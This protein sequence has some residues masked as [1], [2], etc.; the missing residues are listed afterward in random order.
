[1][2]ATARR[3]AVVTGASSGIGR[4]TALELLRRGWEVI[5]T[6]RDAGRIAA[7]EAAIAAE[8]L[9][10]RFTMLRADLALMADAV[11]LA[12]EIAGL[13]DRVDVLVNNAGGM[14]DR[15][16]MTAEG[17][18]ANF[19]G[20][21]LGPFVLTDRLLPL[22]RAAAGGAAAGAVRI[23]M[24]A[25]DASEMLPAL[26]L[27]DIQCLARFNPGMSYCAGKLANVLFAKGLA[28]RLE[29][30]GIVAHSMAPGAVSS[31][32]Y[33]R[34]PQD[35]RERLQDM[36]MFSEVEGADTLI[37]LATAAEPGRSSGGYWEKRQPRQPNPLADDPAV[38]ERFWQES[39]KLVASAGA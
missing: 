30:S 5:G 14:T 27:D 4:E 19:A 13:T 12:G 26:D 18:E 34:A 20:N 23:V 35:T 36:S 7:V 2:N 31:N 16:E 17:L 32:F 9:S 39:K 25:S 38:V 22:L 11:R 29:G 3:V 24:T 37:W 21:H 8:G 1:M 15:L 6:G 33:S 10:E 28:V